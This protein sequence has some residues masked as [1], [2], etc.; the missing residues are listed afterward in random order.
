MA[1]FTAC[2]KNQAVAEAAFAE[3]LPLAQALDASNT[4]CPRFGMLLLAMGNG[5][6]QSGKTKTPVPS[7]KK[8]LPS[9]ARSS[10]TTPK[11]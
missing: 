11:I 4:R 6:N 8:H 2:E 3:G 9:C 5:I 7:C 1:L 10:P